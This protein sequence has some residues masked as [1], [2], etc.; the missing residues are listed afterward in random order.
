MKKRILITGGAGF[1]GSSLYDELKKANEC[2]ILDNFDGF[3]AKKIKYSN[4]GC[5]NKTELKKLKNLYIGS[6]TNRAFLKKLFLE[7]KFD[8]VIHCAAMAGVRSSFE[9]PKKYFEVN[10][11]GTINLLDE[12]R[13]H[14]IKKF[15][16]LS[17]SSVYG[18]NKKLPF[19]EKLEVM[20]ISF[21]AQ[22]K[23][24][25]EEVVSLYSRHFNVDAVIL[26]LFTVY[27]PRQRPDLAIHKFFLQSI[28]GETSEIFGSFKTKRDYTYIA[29]VV[30]GIKKSFAYLIKNNGCETINIGS[31]NPITM[32][33]MIEEIKLII[34][35]FKYKLTDPAEGD[36]EKTFADIRKAEQLLM[37]RPSQNFKSGI[38][39][40]YKW[41]RKT[42]DYD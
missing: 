6:I 11:N 20:P 36:M 17:S 21:Y 3:Y 34:P 12:C 29:D 7:N 41:F 8:A 32:K 1:I 33:E 37:Y 22:T 23:C 27:G 10:V 38:K 18:A 40:F 25:A 5:K 15:L 31:S 30:S 14:K 24:S 26:R 19:N 42:Y 28:K 16:F 13:K 35:E 9:N 39:E 4:L 2:F